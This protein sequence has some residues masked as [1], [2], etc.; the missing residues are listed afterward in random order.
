[1]PGA[2][3]LGRI[4]AHKG[5]YFPNVASMLRGHDAIPALI[6]TLDSKDDRMA[7]H[8]QAILG[9]VHHRL[10]TKQNPNALPQS[11]SGWLEWWKK[12][13]GKLSFKEL[14]SNFDSHYP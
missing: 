10:G 14:W 11:K 9:E 2:F 6:Q 4:E 1:M 12:E 3:Y 5:E 8:A 7:E 13:G